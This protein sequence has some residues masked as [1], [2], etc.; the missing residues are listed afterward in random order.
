M[1]KKKK[2]AKRSKKE[3]SSSPFSHLKGFAVSAPPEAKED[4]FEPPET[5]S[6]ADLSGSFAD[7]MA[8][9]GVERLSLSN[10]GEEESALDSPSQQS[11]P[12]NCVTE[13]EDEIFLQA[14]GE[15]QVNFSD[16]LPEVEKPSVASAQRMRQLKQGR[17][18]PEASLDLHGLTRV[19]VAEKLRFFLQ[20]ASHQNWRTVLVITGRGLHSAAGEPVLRT[21]AE[22][23]LSAEG[24]K[25]VAEWGRAPKQF[26]GAGALVLFLR[27]RTT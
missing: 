11:Q 16:R 5:E 17:L 14:M 3:F 21:E 20:N 9:L 25:W 2:D 26:G 12:E 18:V 19:E 4:R 27:S 7:E 24:Q 8:M 23:F 6:R 15:L 13:N 1:G 22:R 10:D